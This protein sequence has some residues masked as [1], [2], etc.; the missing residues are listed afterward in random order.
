MTVK[1]RLIQ[2]L[3]SQG[4][5]QRAFAEDIGVSSGY[6]NSI[7]VS[8]QPDKL[9]RI[10][11]QY[12]K[13]NIAWLVSGDGEMFK[14][15]EPIKSE[16]LDDNFQNSILNAISAVEKIAESNRMLAESNHEL[17]VTN[18][19]LATSNTGLVQKLAELMD[20]VRGMRT[21]KYS[22]IEGKGHIASDVEKPY[23]KGAE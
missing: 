19:I 10:A 18:K 6:V 13:L 3:N 1:E 21:A 2:F 7:R 5:S 9:H 16:S 8:I 22:T 14:S 12:P 15:A 17:T 11:K 20:E 23:K 4:I